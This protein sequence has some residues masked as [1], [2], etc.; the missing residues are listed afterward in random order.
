MTTIDRDTNGVP[1]IFGATEADV[2]FGFGYAQA[3]DHLELMIRNYREAAGRLTEIEGIAAL[4]TDVRTRQWRTMTAAEASYATLAP[5]TRAYLDAFTEGVNRYITTHP[6]EKVFDCDA[7]SP[8][9]VL[10]LVR[11][12]HIRLNEWRM[13]ELKSHAPSGMSNQWAIAPWKTAAGATLCA[14]DPHT[15]WVPIFRMYEA[16]LISQDGLNVYGG[17]PFGVPTIILGHTDRHAWSFTVNSCDI[18]DLYAE[19]LDPENHRRYRYQD[20]W[21]DIESWSESFRVKTDEGFQTEERTMERTHHGPIVAT[22]AHQAFAL[23]IS[24]DDI[25]DPM[26]VLLGMARA[27]SLDAFRSALDRLELPMFNIVYGD[28][29]GQLYYVYNER[30]P[31]RSEAYNWREPVPG[32]LHATEWQTYYPFTLLPQIEN[33][34]AG[35]LQNCNNSPWYVTPNGGI[36]PQ[37]FPPYV[38]CEEQTGRS[39]RVFDW[40]SQHDK[41]TVEETINLVMD[42]YCITADEFKPKLLAAYNWYHRMIPDPNGTVAQA[43]TLIGNWDNMGDVNSVGMA[44]FSLWKIR[45][46]AITASQKTEAPADKEARFMIEALQDAVKHMLAVYGRVSVPWGDIHRLKRGDKTYPVGGSSQCTEAIRPVGGKMGED[47]QMIA[48]YGSTFTMVVSLETPIQAWTLIPYGAAERPDSPH[49]DDQIRL[50]TE[51]RLKRTYFSKPEI[52]A[53]SK[54]RE[55]LVR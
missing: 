11:L 29:E 9:E 20:D 18:S 42:E 35:F 55:K 33:P 22:V 47:G 5:S 4:A 7:I 41:I 13:P 39:R 37:S 38:T 44:V 6:A 2:A 53:H 23:R 54:R 28:S 31:V 24:A 27:K 34:E 12:I 26:S 19:Q 25:R 30:C 50:W 10:A 36:R 32:W 15:P 14:M 43:I 1:H 49:Y 3:E 46:D 51:R 40:L 48:D 45:Y 21:Y 8:V 17:A 16:H 52:K